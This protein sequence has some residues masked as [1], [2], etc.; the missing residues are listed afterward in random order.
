MM[1]LYLFISIHLIFLFYLLYYLNLLLF[2]ALNPNFVNYSYCFNYLDSK[3]DFLFFQGLIMS[4]KLMDLD[5]L[6]SLAILLF[7]NL[8][9]NIKYFRFNLLEIPRSINHS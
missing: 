4:I 1:D 6:N 7:L 2:L 8:K 5:F 3:I 9:Y